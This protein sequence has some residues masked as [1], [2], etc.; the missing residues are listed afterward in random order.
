[1]EIRRPAPD[2]A[3]Y[4]KEQGSPSWQLLVALGCTFNMLRGTVFGAVAQNITS[5]PLLSSFAGNSRCQRSCSCTRRVR[6]NS[7]ELERGRGLKRY[8][9]CSKWVAGGRRENQAEITEQGVREIGAR[10][11]RQRVHQRRERD[12]NVCGIVW[13]GGPD[14]LSRIGEARSRGQNRRD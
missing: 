1:M 4:L 7:R 8:R 10:R 6:E 3:S 14:K 5:Q 9:S 12:R 2:S 13:L 11:R